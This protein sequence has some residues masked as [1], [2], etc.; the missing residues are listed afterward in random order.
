MPQV[1]LGALP[2]PADPL[3]STPAG[4][5]DRGWVAVA[6]GRVAAA[7]A[8]RDK[9]A[10]E[11]LGAQLADRDR[12]RAASSGAPVHEDPVR[13]AVLALAETVQQACDRLASDAPEVEPGSDLA[14][15]LSAVADRPGCGHD[16]LASTGIDVVATGRVAVRRGLATPTRNGRTSAWSL[17]PRGERAV[18]LL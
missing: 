8:A 5:L 17:T 15:F 2:A 12:E 18:A 1:D 7:V 6:A 4:E 14:R 10:L 13:A 3:A 11:A 16:D 9:E